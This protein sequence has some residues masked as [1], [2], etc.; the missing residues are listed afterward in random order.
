MRILKKIAIGFFVLLLL[1]IAVG[2]SIAYFYGDEIKTV[3][4]E[5]L[6]KSLKTDVEV[7]EVE[8]SMWENFPRASVVFSEVVIHAVDAKNDTLLSAKE[9]SAQFSLFDIYRK[10]YNL[11]ALEVSSGRCSM[12]VD[13]NGRENYV[14]WNK[15]EG[16]TSSF[17]TQLEKV[18]IKDVDF[19]YIDYSKEVAVVFSIDDATIKGDLESS[20]SNL[21]I[22]TVL[23]NTNV[24]VGETTLFENRDL[25]IKVEGQVNQE[26]ESLVFEDANLGIDEMN[27]AISGSY[28]Y[29]KQSNID[30]KFASNNTQLPKAIALLPLSA[31]EK[32]SRFKIDGEASF[33][34]RVFGAFSS[35]QAPAYQLSFSIN[36]GAFKDKSSDLFFKDCTLKGKIDNGKEK[37]LKTTH[38]EIQSF[39]SQL[40]LGKLLG[41]LSLTNFHEPQY[42]FNGTVV[43]DLK[44]LVEIFKWEQIQE[45][46]GRIET[47]LSLKGTLKEAGKY[48]IEDWKRSV[49]RGKTKLVDLAFKLKT[50]EQV[51][52][53]ISGD[54]VFNNNS[55]GVNNLEG[56]VD[57]TQLQVSGK[58]NNLIGYLLEKEESLFVD[59]KLKSSIVDLEDLLGGSKEGNNEE[60]QLEISPYITIYLD[61]EVDSVVFDKLEL[62]NLKTTLII[63]NER[64]DA[65]GINFNAMGGNIEGDFFIKE[66]NKGSLNIFSQAV[67]TAVDIERMF[68]SFNNF[69]Q[70][71]LKAEH[72]SGNVDAE[73]QFN[74]EWTKQFI[75]DQKSIQVEANIIINDGVLEEFKPLES[76]SK[77]VELEELKRVE[78]KQIN[79]QVLIKDELVTIPRFD[80]YSSALNMSIA[81]TH[82]F[83][84]EIDYHFTLLLSDVLGRKA[85]K[86]KG[87]E[88]GYV[89]DDGLGK[90]KLFLKM[91]GTVD[92]PEVK[93][94]SKQ[95]RSTLKDKITN[96][97]KVFKGILKEEFGFFKKDTTLTPSKTS[98]TKP[99]QSPFQVEIDSS[100]LKKSDKNQTN[101]NQEVKSEDKNEKGNKSKFGKFLDKIAK[102]NEEEF[103]EPIEN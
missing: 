28:G 75:V 52:S 44:E 26:K 56:K 48:D 81:G 47:D 87:N 7:K 78:F 82:S 13:N 25:Y 38:L 90:S 15:T 95:L 67:L 24:Q 16:D 46:A 58:F 79:N 91:T 69:G 68:Y 98:H 32:L 4:V 80:L 18:K 31:R 33:N 65:R 35:F 93:Y 40:S 94:D 86:P 60:Y 8:F 19:S 30:V 74:S 27:L 14:F 97:K 55:V 83:K 45:A 11:L 84:N 59:A 96:E 54:L 51:F 70:S 20:I 21:D 29:G 9:L 17:S 10:K 2:G 41:E 6:N 88:F 57:R 103:V 22:T 85:K 37:N 50:K 76:L 53:A 12:V 99:K 101:G 61:A 66:N 63:K 3:V 89:E 100:Y 72:L 73:V 5:N 23:K 62:A 39:E 92:N 64:I 43:L 49:V 36:E 1:I 102:P 34:G 42:E 71:T 77:F